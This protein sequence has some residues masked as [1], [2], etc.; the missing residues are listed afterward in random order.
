MSFRTQWSCNDCGVAFS[1]P[2]SGGDKQ[3]FSKRGTWDCFMC[4]K[5]LVPSVSITGRLSRSADAPSNQMAAE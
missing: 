3:Q 4:N 2:L 1:A 5:E